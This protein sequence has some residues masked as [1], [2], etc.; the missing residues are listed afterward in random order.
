MSKFLRNVLGTSL[1]L[2]VTLVVAN[3]ASCK[4]LGGGGTPFEIKSIKLWGENIKGK[5]N[6][7]ITAGGKDNSLEIVVGNAKNY[8][9]K[10]SVT[11]KEP[12]TFTAS[13]DKAEHNVV[14]SSGQSTINIEIT[15]EGMAKY[16]QSTE[17]N[18]KLKSASITV[19]LKRAEDIGF[20]LVGDGDV[21]ETNGTEAEIM[22]ESDRSMASAKVGNV[23]LQFSDGNKI[24]TGKVSAGKV[25]VSAE[26]LG[27]NDFRLVFTLQKVDHTLKLSP[28]KVAIYSG[29]DKKDGGTEK[30]LELEDK[31]GTVYNQ[32]VLDDVEYGVVRLEMEFDATLEKVEITRCKDGRTEDYYTGLTTKNYI[33]GG[34]F[35]GRVFKEVKIVEQDG[36]KKT[37]ETTLTNVEGSKYTEYLIVGKGAVEYDIMVYAHK[38]VPVKYTIKIK[39]EM[40]KR[41]QLSDAKAVDM[42]LYGPYNLAE[43]LLVA[44]TYFIWL[45]YLRSPLIPPSDTPKEE[46]LDWVSN[47]EYMGDLVTMTFFAEPQK[48]SKLGADGMQFF[49]NVIDEEK[50]KMC[51]NFVRV[52]GGKDSDGYLYVKPEIDPQGKRVDAY[53]GF[54][55]A[56]PFPLLP[57]NASK[58][59][60]KI[61]EKGFY[62]EADASKA[63]HREFIK[64]FYYR[65]QAKMFEKLNTDAKGRLDENAMKIARKLEYADFREG[66]NASPAESLLT[67]STANKEK[68]SGRDC[69]YLRKTFKEKYSEVFDKVA[70]EIKLKNKSGEWETQQSEDYE[71]EKWDSVPYL[72]VGAKQGWIDKWTAGKAVNDVDCTDIFCFEKGEQYS[73]NLYKIE[74]TTKLKGSGKEEYFDM[75]LD[76]SDK[77]TEHKPLGLE[78]VGSTYGATDLFGLPVCFETTNK[79]VETEE[80]LSNMLIKQ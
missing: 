49:Y 59:F 69:F 53:L 18:V 56:L 43:G 12:I 63:I 78:G 25:E 75:I 26:V 19:K 79:S 37:V 74:I 7:D 6:I 55:K 66:R 27:F 34:I 13:G 44:G 10:C 54:Q 4:G 28:T 30:I 24:A 65:N 80:D 50:D 5:K 40:T 31:N 15:A 39:N 2:L 17:I 72:I 8:N 14:L 32:V 57:T 35:S 47:V 64:A 33:Q 70:C 67:G 36:K 3:F 71:L 61:I 77:I 22:L 29:D 1:L 38:R 60:K 42:G 11:G 23:P 21:K 48:M 9:V 45:G 58:P 41:F 73:E 62:V 51:H 20:L 52:Y 46:A 16:T 68:L 76:Y